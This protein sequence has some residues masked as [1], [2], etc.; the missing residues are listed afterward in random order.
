M[1]LVPDVPYPQTDPLTLEDF[2][3]VVCLM[4]S[5]PSLFFYNCGVQSGASQPHKHIQVRGTLSVDT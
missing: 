2:K 4:D 3:R 1:L 5:I